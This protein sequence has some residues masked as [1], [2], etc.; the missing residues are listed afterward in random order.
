MKVPLLLSVVLLTGCA[1]DL[2]DPDVPLTRSPA[3]TP[4]NARSAEALGGSSGFR[5]GVGPVEISSTYGSGDIKIGLSLT[6]EEDPRVEAISLEYKGKSYTQRLVGI[7]GI[8][9]SRSWVG[10]QWDSLDR[11]EAIIVF[12][13]PVSLS[14][15]PE[16]FNRRIGVTVNGGRGI[17]INF[18][19][20]YVKSGKPL[21]DIYTEPERPDSP[22]AV[23]GCV[24]NSETYCR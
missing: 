19:N 21:L 2:S 4:A 15:D 23:S 20:I 12:L 24:R 5:S 11:S 17:I 14:D 8:D 10:A 1:S 18:D 3:A 13:A 7:A 9:L 6:R 16:N 22:E